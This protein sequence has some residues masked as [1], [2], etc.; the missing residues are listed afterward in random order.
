MGR[1]AVFGYDAQMVA[2]AIAFCLQPAKIC[3]QEGA[4]LDDQGG[5]VQARF[6]AGNSRERSDEPFFTVSF[7]HVAGHLRVSTPKQRGAAELGRPC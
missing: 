3:D 4:S 2:E 7:R 6:D 1:V 5:I